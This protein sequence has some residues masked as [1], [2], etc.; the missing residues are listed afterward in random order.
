[1]NVLLALFMDPGKSFA[2]YILRVCLVV[3][4]V[5]ALISS[6]TAVIFP[7]SYDALALSA[8]VTHDAVAA[9]SSFLIGSAIAVA[10]LVAGILVLGR[11]LPDRPVAIAMVVGLTGGIV[12]TA[13]QGP[14]V[15][16]TALWLFFAASLAF[17][18][19]RITSWLHGLSAAFCV[20][21][22]YNGLSL[23]MW[24]LS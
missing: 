8:G 6:L 20:W 24:T 9:V 23:L 5:G 1:M 19:G 18:V 4:A 12:Y 21:F 16:L 7:G 11:F 2:G 13:L 17:H 22:S 10:L 15:G 3:A 14:V